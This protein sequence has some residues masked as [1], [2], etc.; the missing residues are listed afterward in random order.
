MS[1]LFNLMASSGNVVPVGVEEG[2]L[3]RA[4]FT[5]LD[6]HAKCNYSAWLR[7][8]IS[9]EEVKAKSPENPN[10][11]RGV[12]LHDMV[13]QYT[14]GYLNE[15]PKDIKYQRDYIEQCR[16]MVE[17]GKKVY[18]EVPWYFD[19]EWGTLPDKE[20]QRI[21]MKL[22]QYYFQS[23]QVMVID[24][25][26]SGKAIGNEAKHT[27]QNKFY[28]VGAFMR[29]PDLQFI[30]TN[31]RY[32]DQDF[33]LPRPYTREQAMAFYRTFNNQLR[34]FWH[35][36]KYVPRPSRANCF[37]C[38]YNKMNTDGTYFCAYGVRND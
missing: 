37:L 31:V 18:S 30:Q 14:K 13:E 34:L 11:D 24:E 6:L 32:F 36:T 15:L 1:T 22:D 16:E 10:A 23:E 9:Y 17:S 5:L 20:G 38:Q 28:A 7:N 27:R 19:K 3:R 8:T 2:V 33:V 21:V 4:S 25:W 29:Y 26:K 35:D 12:N